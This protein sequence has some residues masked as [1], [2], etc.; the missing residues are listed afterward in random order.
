MKIN[1]ALLTPNAYSRPQKNLKKVTNIVI[2]WVGNPGS[3]AMANRNY[4]ES[5]KKGPTYASAHYIIGLEGEIIQCIP[6]EEIAYH[7]GVANGYS[8][9]IENCHPDKKGKFNTATYVALIGL[10]ADICRRYILDPEKALLRHYDITGKICPKY[11]VENTEAWNQLK[12]DV[13]KVLYAIGDDK[14]LIEAVNALIISGVSIDINVWGNMK[15]MN[16]KYAKQLV[17]KIGSKY[18]CSNY[19]ETIDFL[20]SKQCILTREPWDEEKFKA[21]WC[22]ALMINIKEKLL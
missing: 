2:H 13:K 22:R 5:L 1:Q 10:C 8:I 15:T 14:E 12:Q 3:T 19:K 16:L 11:Y 6:E 18:K 7:A 17:E 21:E 4:F 20:V 9:G